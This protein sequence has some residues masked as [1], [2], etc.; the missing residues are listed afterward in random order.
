MRGQAKTSAATKRQTEMVLPK[1]RGVEMRISWWMLVHVLSSRMRGYDCE[2]KPGGS[3]L[4]RTRTTA[5]MKRSWNTR[6]WYERSQPPRSSALS[7]LRR[8]SRRSKPLMPALACVV[9]V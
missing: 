5:L 2:K 4:N 3:V 1:R 8:F 7:A 9:S 6:W